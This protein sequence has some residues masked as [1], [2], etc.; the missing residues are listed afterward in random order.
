[1]SFL[2]TIFYKPYQAHLCVTSANGFHLRPVAS[3]ASTAKQ[4]PCSIFASFKDKKVDAKNIN[5]LLSL[6]LDTQDCF[7]LI[8]QGRKA[9]EALE[10]LTKQF[11]FLMQNDQEIHPIQKEKIAYEGKI[12][13]GDIIAEGIAIAKLYEHTTQEVSTQNSLGFQEA[14]KNS[15]QELDMLHTLHQ[16]TPD[17][18]IYLAQKELL[19]TLTQKNNTLEDFEDAVQQA[20]C[21]LGET[22]MKAKISDYQDLLW[23]VKKHLGIEE[24]M[25]LPATPFILFAEDLLPNQIEQLTQSR[26]Q[27]VILKKSSLRSHAAILLRAAG[28]PSLILAL[29]DDTECTLVPDVIVLDAYAGVLIYTPSQNDLQKATERL[30]KNKRTKRH[31]RSQRFKKAL[32]TQGK[33][34]HL[35]ANVSDV[36]SAKEAKEEG[37]EGIGLLRSEF[38][39]T[40]VKP[41]FE[42]QVH[43]YKE[44]FAL[45]DNITVRTLDIGGDKALPYIRLPHENNP[46]LGVRGIRLFRTHP[47]IIEEQLHAIF[48]AAQKKPIKIM[49][50]MVAQVE[51]FI[52]AKAFAYRIAQKHELDISSIQFGI[53]IEVPSVLFLL[54]RFNSVVDFYSIGTNDLS[55]YLFAVERTHPTL[56]LDAHS[57]ILF[58]VL[59]KIV[60]EAAKPLS[61]CGELA[62][63]AKA[64]P[65]L[66]TLGIETLSVSPKMISTVK[67]EIR[68]V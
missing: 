44:I 47:E 40:Q 68:H 56:K 3:F 42:T 8:T 67:E 36:K 55:Q 30:Q 62:S 58:D 46:F 32:T 34:I 15:L 60:K 24:K 14:L 1:M 17:A 50:P 2:T 20:S 37:A 31:I 54:Q 6:S 26:V 28:I 10:A 38:L 11:S 4:F 45:F 16:T 12:L 52:E 7:T 64:I 33:P 53:M 5:A 23:R 19:K 57:S 21:S 59:E 51:E 39:F 41:S 61:L 48:V 66:I 63:E 22:S 25:V 13:E 9:E 43:A 49:F 18:S 29:P 27:G 65:K 35:L